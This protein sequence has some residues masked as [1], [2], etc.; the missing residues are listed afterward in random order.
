M[1]PANVSLI[2]DI[3]NDK[4][5]VCS[6]VIKVCG[7]TTPFLEAVDVELTYCNDDVA[8]VDEI[9]L[10]VGNKIKFSTELGLLIRQKETESKCQKL[11]E[12]TEV[13]IERSRNGKVK[14]SFSLKHFSW[15]VEIHFHTLICKAEKQCTALNCVTLHCIALHCI[16]WYRIISYRI[17]VLH[18][19][20]WYGMAS[21]HIRTVLQKLWTIREMIFCSLLAQ[22]NFK[23]V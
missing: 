11:N 8:D 19:M 12:S 1:L 6:P 20:V 9:F 7:Q 2:E 23:I 22:V 18:W 5:L 13:F 10:P 15:Y 14:F 4:S 21:Y 17:G 3:Y 16:V